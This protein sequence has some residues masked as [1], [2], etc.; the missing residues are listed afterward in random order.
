MRFSL[1]PATCRVA[2]THWFPAFL[3]SAHLSS[4]SLSYLRKD[5]NFGF[6]LAIPSSSVCVVGPQLSPRNCTAGE[7]SA[8]PKPVLDLVLG[9]CI[10]HTK[11]ASPCLSLLCDHLPA[12]WRKTDME[13][14]DSQEGSGLRK[15]GYGTATGMLCN[16]FDGHFNLAVL[17]APHFS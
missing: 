1:I 2:E 12:D 6:L 8:Q 11:M 13:A 10:Q 16:A 7:K 9:D 3:S 15:L 14:R 17:P 5:L 4:A